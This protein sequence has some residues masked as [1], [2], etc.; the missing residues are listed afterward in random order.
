MR[1]VPSRLVH[2]VKVTASIKVNFP[3]PTKNV[4][5]K[6]RT[7]MKRMRNPQQTKTTRNIT[8]LLVLPA[9]EVTG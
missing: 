5:N 4:T 3:I 9:K 6:P 8:S 2:P 1:T 7:V